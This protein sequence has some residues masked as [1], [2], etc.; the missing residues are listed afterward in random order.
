MTT[1]QK[2]NTE[3]TLKELAENFKSGKSYE[4]LK[5]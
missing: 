4:K 1:I 2:Y 3:T 5:S